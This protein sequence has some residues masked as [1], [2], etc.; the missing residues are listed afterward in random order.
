MMNTSTWLGIIGSALVLC[1]WFVFLSIRIHLLKRYGEIQ[2]R[3]AYPVLIGFG[4]L[5]IL[6]VRLEFGS[7]I[8]APGTPARQLVSGSRF[9]LLGVG[10]FADAVFP[11]C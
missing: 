11:C 9:Y 10:Y 3:I 4:L 1:Q 6:A 8:F 7:E 2:R 5:T